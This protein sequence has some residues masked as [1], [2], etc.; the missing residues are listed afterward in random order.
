[1]KEVDFSFEE[2]RV[3]QKSL[4]FIDDVYEITNEF[5][6]E[7]R[8]GLTSQFRRAAQ[9]IVLNI[10]EGSGDT[11]AQFKRF[12]SLS[13]GSIKEC[14]VCATIAVRRLIISETKNKKLRVSLS[15]MAKMITNLQKYLK[16]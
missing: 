6:S 12:L 4:D 9:S 7:E 3:Y 10:A 14:V 2:L 11:D 13:Q 15:I 8:F 16:K 5:P 1:M